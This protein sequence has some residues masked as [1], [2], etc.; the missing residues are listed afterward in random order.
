MSVHPHS[1]CAEREESYWAQYS[2]IVELVRALESFGFHKYND[3]TRCSCPNPP[4]DSEGHHM[5]PRCIRARAAI[6]EARMTHYN[7]NDTTNGG[8]SA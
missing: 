3:G 1:S 4:Q 6:K 5:S 7:V 2:A 8:Q